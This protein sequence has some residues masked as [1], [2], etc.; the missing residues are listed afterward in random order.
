MIEKNFVEVIGESSYA[1]SVENGYM[2]YGVR[3]CNVY[4]S[5]FGVHTDIV[6]AGRNENGRAF[7]RVSFSRTNHHIPASEY[8]QAKEF[9]KNLLKKLESDSSYFEML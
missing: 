4:T 2:G 9:A 8:K 7:C 3:A 6:T 1:V 5:D